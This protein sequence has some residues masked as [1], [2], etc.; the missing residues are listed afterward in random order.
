MAKKV[1]D[2]IAD[3]RM[4]WIVTFANYFFNIMNLRAFAGTTAQAIDDGAESVRRK[5]QN[6]AKEAFGDSTVQKMFAASGALESE[7]LL[8]DITDAMARRSIRLAKQTADSATLIFAHSMLDGVLIDACM[9]SFLARPA[10]WFPFVYGR[11]IELRF[12]LPGKTK[13]LIQKSAEDFVRQLGRESMVKRAEYLQRICFPKLKGS[14]FPMGWLAQEELES[15]DKLRHGIVH[16]RSFAK[17]V[18]DVDKQVHFAFQSG[19]TAL[20]LVNQAYQLSEKEDVSSASI[21]RI[22]RLFVIAKREFPEF[23]EVFKRHIE[24]LSKR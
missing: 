14:K 10:D 15:F 23:V 19:M 8:H 11:K 6:G 13:P 18:V 20:M 24:R 1:K 9:I 21:M 4:R 16:G 17:K 12:L 2:S 5:W 22:L 3:A 7:E